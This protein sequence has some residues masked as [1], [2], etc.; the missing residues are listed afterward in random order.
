METPVF[1]F[2]DVSDNRLRNRVG[3]ACKDYGL[4]RV[5]NSAFF[6]RISRNKREE[7]C[8]RLREEIGKEKALLVLQPVCEKCIG[9]MF[10]IGGISDQPRDPDIQD[11]APAAMPDW[12]SPIRPGSL[13]LTED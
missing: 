6:G 3:D 1:V 8:F 5:Q 13:P 11:E 12:N 4:V 9:N 7:L 10:T 2:F